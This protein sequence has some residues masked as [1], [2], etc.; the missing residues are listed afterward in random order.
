MNS[1]LPTGAL[2]SPGPDVAVGAAANGLKLDSAMVVRSPR[3]DQ[4]EPF[5][6]VT[7]GWPDDGAIR[8]RDAVLML[9]LEFAVITTAHW[10]GITGERTA[11]DASGP[12]GGPQHH[13]H[14]GGPVAPRRT[15]RTCELRSTE[16]ARVGRGSANLHDQHGADP[17]TVPRARDVREAEMRT[18]RSAW[19]DGEPPCESATPAGCARP[20]SGR[21]DSPSSPVFPRVSR[22]CDP[23]AAAI[24]RP[25][26]AVAMC[27]AESDRTIPAFPE[28]P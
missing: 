21:A 15:G 3:R 13:S 28:I 27:P 24:A 12:R 9:W 11:E 17:D 18:R 20:T 5:R 7:P 22:E 2:R 19:F 23:S 26:P 25:G 4:P 8:A 16:R 1:E 10:P 14:S 6:Q